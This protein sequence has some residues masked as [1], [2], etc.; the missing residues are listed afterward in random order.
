MRAKHGKKKKAL[1]KASSEIAPVYD[2]IGLEPPRI[3]AND[4]YLVY[5]DEYGSYGSRLRTRARG[6]RHLAP[7]DNR[8]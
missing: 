6:P 4:N 7:T 3:S 8:R 2:W 1:V 5:V